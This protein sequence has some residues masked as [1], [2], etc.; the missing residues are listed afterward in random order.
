M[1][2]MITP[3]IVTA[4]RL[5]GDIGFE[6]EWQAAQPHEIRFNAVLDVIRPSRRHPGRYA[7]ETFSSNPATGWRCARGVPG[8][9]MTGYSWWR[10]GSPQHH[11]H[12][13]LAETGS[14]PDRR[15]ATRLIDLAGTGIVE[16]KAAANAAGLRN[17]GAPVPPASAASAC[18]WLRLSPSR[19]QQGDGREDAD[20]DPQARDPAGLRRCL[21][22]SAAEWSSAGGRP[23][24]ARPQA[25]P[26]SPALA[27]GARRGEIRQDAAVRPR[28]CRRSAARVRADLARPGLPREKVLAAIVRL[29]ETT[30]IRVGNE[31]YA[32]HQQELSA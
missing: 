3:H 2:R 14:P 18:R 5:A 30:L 25:V 7:E 16:P 26:L 6:F 1:E 15:H 21:D 22:L 19:R 28:R 31:E 12:L 13:S 20:P 32:K 23:G 24:C 10:Y 8:K 11:A 29:L 4:R 17:V 27:R 9:L